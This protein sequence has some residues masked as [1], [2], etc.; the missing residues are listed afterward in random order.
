MKKIIYSIIAL[1][2]A[3]LLNIWLYFYSESYSFFLKK[4]KYWDEL[5]QNES[6]NITDN[7]SF[8]PQK[9]EC[10]CESVKY[11]N[12]QNNSD[13]QKE[14]ILP[15]INTLSWELN[16]LFTHFDKN[17]LVEKKFD[18][19]YQ[20][21]NITDEYPTEYKTFTNENFELYLFNSWKFDDLYN[22][23][24]VLSKDQ[25]VINKFSLNKSNNFWKQ[26]FY[27]NTKIDDWYARVVVSNWKILFWL[28][29]KKWYYNVIKPIL[30]K[31]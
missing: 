20:I 4:L 8:T 6:Q 28:K 27:I 29:V 2:L 16:E 17:T 13:I 24:D 9:N 21:F 1:V 26:S 18:E 23:F 15:Q 14:N 25:N 31:F 7:Y 30:E 10:T 19:Y 22:L 12:C 5:I 3:F 11:L